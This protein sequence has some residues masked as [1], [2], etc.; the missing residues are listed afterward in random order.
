FPFYFSSSRADKPGDL[1]PDARV[2]TETAEGELEELPPLLTVLRSGTKR[3]SQR[4]EVPVELEA[5][6]TELGVLE[7]ACHATDG[8]DRRWDL[9]LSVRKA[10]EETKRRT[11]EGTAAQ[12][13]T[14]P[15]E[16][17]STAAPEAGREGAPAE[18]E[19]P[20]VD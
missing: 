3:T 1:V 7:L 20:P 13:G 16:G 9:E 18:D 5:K 8:T 14:R 10:G 2:A 17:A 4:K 6:L 19:G 12:A 11:R 15:A